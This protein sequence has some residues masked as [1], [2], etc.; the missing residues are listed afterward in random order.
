MYLASS[1]LDAEEREGK[2]KGAGT[3]MDDIVQIIARRVL[4]RARQSEGRE[5]GNKTPG[6]S[7]AKVMIS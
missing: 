3:A 4:D 5:G 6:S 7:A 1:R 2:H